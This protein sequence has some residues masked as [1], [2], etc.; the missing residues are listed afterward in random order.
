MDLLK[1]R[2]RKGRKK[3]RLSR[4]IAKN[5]SCYVYSGLRLRFFLLMSVKTSSVV[6][7]K[8]WRDSWAPRFYH[9]CHIRFAMSFITNLGKFLIC[10]FHE[11]QQNAL[12]WQ[13]AWTW[14]HNFIVLLYWYT[15]RLGYL[16]TKI[17][18]FHH[19]FEVLII[20]DYVYKCV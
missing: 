19:R 15:Y 2:W 4:R 11:V 17:L 10:G 1:K 6:Q 7:K 3:R 16:P 9:C 12:L 14:W 18:T 5:C 8:S 13:N 20:N